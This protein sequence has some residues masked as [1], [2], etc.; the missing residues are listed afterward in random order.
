VQSRYEMHGFT[1][2]KLVYTD[3][4]PADR[5]F[6]CKMF[7]SLEEGAVLTP[8]QLPKLILPFEPVL[9]RESA[10]ADV[11][12]LQIREKMHALGA[13]AIG[14]DLEWDLPVGN[15]RQPISLLRL[16]LQSGET[17]L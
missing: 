9:I 6:L 7:P 1:K 13:T 2:P 10:A 16:A 15:T 11:A 3:R 17:W 14:F 8:L 12:V 5:A 4:A